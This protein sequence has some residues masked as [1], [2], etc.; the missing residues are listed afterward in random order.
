MAKGTLFLTVAPHLRLRKAALRG[1]EVVGLLTRISPSQLGQ[2][3]GITG[4]VVQWQP[5]AGRFPIPATGKET[6]GKERAS[7][8]PV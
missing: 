4:V 8:L 2:W 1:R 3:T 6:E 7:I 5:E